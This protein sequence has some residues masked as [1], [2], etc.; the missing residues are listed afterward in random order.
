MNIKIT[1]NPVELGKVSAAAA[2]EGIINAIKEKGQANVILATGASQ[3][4]T[5]K[6]LVEDTTIDWSKVVMFHLDEYIGLPE[7]A[8]ASFRKYLKERFLNLVSPL[9]ASYLVNGETDPEGECERLN[10][11]I[12]DHPIDVAFVGIG[13]NGHLAFNDPPAD[14]DT[15]SP[16]IVVDLDEKCRLQQ[17]NEGW[18]PSL[19]EVPKKAISMSIKQICKSKMIICSVPDSR[20]AE[21]VKNTLENKVSNNDPA[22]ILQTHANCLFIL[23]KSSASLLSKN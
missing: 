16:Y 13:E 4:E 18:F 21:A 17:F 20:K 23:D 12:T 19:A 22:S 10:Q 6:N 11:I 3:F 7:T 15:V 1:D 9:K 5:L 2:V 14:F 8:P